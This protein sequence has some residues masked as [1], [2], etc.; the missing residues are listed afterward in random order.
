[1][2]PEKT[3]EKPEMHVIHFESEDIIV[4]SSAVETP[5]IPIGPGGD[6]TLPGDPLSR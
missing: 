2:K 1:M 5:P 4:M 3:Y 6:D